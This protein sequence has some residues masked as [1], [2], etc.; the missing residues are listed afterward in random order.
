MFLNDDMLAFEIE[1]IFNE[2]KIKVKQKTLDKVKEIIIHH[3][4]SEEFRK[5]ICEIM[6]TC[7]PKSQQLSRKNKQFQKDGSKKKMILIGYIKS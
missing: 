1:K 3:Y 5:E 4:D 7:E 2:T 6:D